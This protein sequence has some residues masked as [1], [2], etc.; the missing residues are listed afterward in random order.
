MA[1]WNPESYAFMNLV[2][3]YICR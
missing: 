1:G 2:R 3:M